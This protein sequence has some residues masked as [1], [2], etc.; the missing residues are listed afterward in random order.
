MEVIVWVGVFAFVTHFHPRDDDA[1]NRFSISV[2]SLRTRNSLRA[3]HLLRGLIPSSGKTCDAR[4]KFSIFH[5]LAASFNYL[6]I[7][8][9]FFPSIPR[10]L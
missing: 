3:F 7:A 5:F 8:F 9:R 6:E 10:A 4:E 1:A 2:D